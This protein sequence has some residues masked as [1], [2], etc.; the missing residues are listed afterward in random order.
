MRRWW[1]VLGGAALVGAFGLIVVPAQASVVATPGAAPVAP[2]VSPPG[3]G[4]VRSIQRLRLVTGDSVRIVTFADGTQV[5]RVAQRKSFI[6]SGGHDGLRV[7]PR[8]SPALLRRLDPALFDTGA[9]VRARHDGRT[10]IVVTFRSGVSP[11]R[12]TGI[13]VAPGAHGD[14][15]SRFVRGSIGP[16]FRGFTAADLR[17]VT[18]VE[19]DVPR[20]DAADRAAADPIHRVR[21][22]VTAGDASPADYALVTLQ[23]TVDGDSYLEQANVD[24]AGDASFAAVPAGEYSVVVQ[25]FEQVLV[26]P[27]LTVDADRVVEVDLDDATVKP[28]VRLRGHRT[29]QTSLTVQRSPEKGFGIS[30]GYS[31]P[32]F[33]M[34]VQ[35]TSG[36]VRHGALYTGVTTVLVAG[37]KADG[38]RDVAMTQDVAAGVPARL[39]F[40]HRAREFARLTDRFYGN[41]PTASRT[42]MLVPGDPRADLSNGMADLQ[43]PVPGTLRLWVQAGSHTSA[44]QT[45]FP[46]STGDAE[47][48][49]TQ[50]LDVRRYRHAGKHAPV[51]FLH[52]PVGPGSEVAPEAPYGTGGARFGDRLWLGVPLFGGAGGTAFSITDRRDATW[53]LSLGRRTL[54]RGH[55]EIS[56]PIRVPHRRRTYQLVAGTHPDKAWELST[57]VTVRWTFHS[58][59]GRSA[60]PLLTPRYVPPTSL[61]GTVRPGHTGYRLAFHSTHRSPRVRWARVEISTDDGRTWRR[62]RVTR[63][64]ALAFHVGYHNPRAQGDARYL[65]LRITAS[66]GGSN[67]VEETAIRAFR[68]R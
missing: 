40:V 13:R 4:A 67:R 51:S 46:F 50:V 61:S 35:P 32:S 63:T 33:D 41:G 55:Q 60:I 42:L 54:A 62:V 68:L 49:N 27:E 12:V 34:K 66:D 16:R 24:D 38:Y 28:R 9:L 11:R 59:A 26:T 7:V 65:S 31:G 23:N 29:L 57:D 47:G 15:G 3:H 25:T 64:S 19:L 56:R 52:G 22:H 21:V 48:D 10:P 58:R 5:P 20:P 45:V 1:I 6:W 37:R 8:T 30:F 36:K 17:D 14:G 39:T 53:S 43:V 2:R 44:Q 18:R